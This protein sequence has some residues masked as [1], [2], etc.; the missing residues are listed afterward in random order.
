M[1]LYSMT[2]IAQADATNRELMKYVLD[3]AWAIPAPATPQYH[4]WWPW[5]KNY[6]GEI[7]MGYDNAY[8]YTKYIWLDQN[9]KESMGY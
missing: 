4:F 3:Q 6:H 8:T 5:V 1:M 2:D 9:M 7:S